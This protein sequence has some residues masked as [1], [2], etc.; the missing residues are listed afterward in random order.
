MK[1]LLL[2]GVLCALLVLAF[3][4][5]SPAFAQDDT[6]CDDYATQADAQ[7]ALDADRSDPN[8]LDAD[9]DGQACEDSGLPGGAGGSAGT[10]T[11]T[12]GGST[13]TT[14]G[15]TTT[16][17]STTTTGT[18]TTGT[19]TGTTTGASAL[20]DTGGASPMLPLASLAMALITGASILAAFAMRR[21]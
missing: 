3:A 8:N 17:T 21:S 12:T 6:N 9:D 11:T 19:S 13:T 14:S 20:P 16:G 5:A 10:S 7:A 4:P 1:K 18:T 15:S 2:M